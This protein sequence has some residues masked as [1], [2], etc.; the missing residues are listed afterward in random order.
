MTHI[1]SAADSVSD[2]THPV[3]TFQI[4]DFLFAYRIVSGGLSGDGTLFGSI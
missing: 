4:H 1:F 2:D 3:I